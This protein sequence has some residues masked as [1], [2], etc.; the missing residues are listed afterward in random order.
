ME[1]Q[2][3]SNLQLVSVLGTPGEEVREAAGQLSPRFIQGK[4]VPCHTC[5]TQGRNPL[6]PCGLRRQS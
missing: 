1:V 2:E 5:A 3:A 4:A 6:Q